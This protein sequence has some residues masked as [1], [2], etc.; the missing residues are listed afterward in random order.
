MSSI[1]P[2]THSNYVTEEEN[3]EFNCFL[4]VHLTLAGFSNLF[5]EFIDFST[6]EKKSTCGKISLWKWKLKTH[7]S[8]AQI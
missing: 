6:E 4:S 7:G 5:K 1:L 8:K 3:L 2:K